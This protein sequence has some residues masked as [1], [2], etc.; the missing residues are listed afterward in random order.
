MAKRES[1]FKNMLLTLLLV[2]AGAGAALSGV[3]VMTL[4]PIAIAKA[5]KTENAIKAVLTE[6]DRYEVLGV[7]IENKKSPLLY[8]TG[9]APDTLF[10]YKAYK[11]DKYIGTA[12][13]SSTMKG[14]SGEIIIMVG[15][16]ADGKLI[17]TAVLEHKETPGLGDKMSIKKSKFPEQFMGK[18]PSAF[19]LTVKQDGGDVQAITAA[20]I[21]SRAFCDAVQKAIE[22]VEKLDTQN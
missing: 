2:T 19:S 14:F 21:S 9:L 22:T 13:K 20:T 11:Q 18:D 4:E 10:L 5:Q 15:I 1:S 8:K 7:P 3:H 16:G 12:V 17:N 6:F